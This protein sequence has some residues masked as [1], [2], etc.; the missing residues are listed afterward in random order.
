MQAGR[1]RFGRQRRRI[2]D[3]RAGDVLLQ[4]SVP[5]G[6][7]E[8]LPIESV[9]VEARADFEGVGLAAS[10][11]TYRARVVSPASQAEIEA[12]QERTDAVAEVQNTLRAGRSVAR[13]PWAH[14]D[15]GDAAPAD[16]L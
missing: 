6:G 9:Q 16:R 11:I 13:R 14:E 4:R 15:P 2:P 10:N 1:I 7:S 8:Q 3:A 12:L 5:R